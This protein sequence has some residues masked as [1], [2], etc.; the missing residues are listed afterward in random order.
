M[1]LSQITFAAF[2]MFGIATAT[3][4]AQES[5]SR[6]LESQKPEAQAS[7]PSILFAGIGVTDISPP[8]AFPMAGYYHERLS[9]GTA[10]PL[11]AKAI[12]FRQGK[13]FAAIVV[14][15]LIGISTDL[16][17]EIRKSA[18]QKTGIP[19]DNIVVA[20]THTHTA[21]DYMRELWWNLGGQRQDPARAKYVRP[22]ID[23]PVE[24]IVAAVSDLQP[25]SLASGS[26]TQKT[27]VA[28]N[29]RFVMRDGTVKTWQ[30]FSNPNVV[31][32]AGP[33]DPE[34]GLLA[35]RDW[36][37]KKTRGIISNFALHLDTV[38][39]TKWSADYPHFISETIKKAVGTDTVS[40]FAT[41]C[42]GDINHSDPDNAA[43]NKAD[44]I[45]NSIGDSIVGELKDLTTLKQ[46]DL[47]VKSMIVK[48]PLREVTTEDVE[49]AI[50]VITAANNKEKV[51]FFEH[52]TAHIKLT[53]DRLRN[54][55]PIAK[56]N[57][58]LRSGISR[59]LAGVGEELPVQITAI[60]LGQDVAIVC[61]PGEV[62]VELGLAIKRASPFKT[63]IV[64]ELSN[65]GE[66]AYIPNRIAYAGGGY[67][68]TNS[69]LKP[70][71]GEILVESAL[72][73]LQQAV[74][75]RGSK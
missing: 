52:V 18:F 32:T 33:I 62:F 54:R 2:C 24:A 55:K 17:H 63:T 44:F 5:Q 13:K 10:D 12:V 68:V 11:K 14:C 65:A 27:P 28:F 53:L 59:K 61:L 66:T 34:I 1:T 69:T 22:L 46:T 42:C 43:R 50:E 70:G 73:L 67:E 51:D 23:G 19:M 40:V 21:P 4:P 56:A 6:K 7:D 71:G 20:A 41:G 47:V 31:R 60:T 48:L 57:E 8:L 49:K 26:A 15:D 35:I 37:T 58:L 9:D 45:G 38:G 39:G 25:S 72:T 30:K 29:R 75:A 16:S 74:A 36:K 64:I 3:S